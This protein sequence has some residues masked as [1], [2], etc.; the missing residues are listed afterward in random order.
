MFNK[1]AIGCGVLH[2]VAK[3]IKNKL[4]VTSHFAKNVAIVNELEGG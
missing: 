2:N 4:T 1:P 3:E